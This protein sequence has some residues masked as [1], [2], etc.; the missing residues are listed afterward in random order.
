[1]EVFTKR[2]GI[3]VA[4]LVI[5]FLIS[6][7]IGQSQNTQSF[8]AA[9]RSFE[10]QDYQKALSEINSFL[11]EVDGNSYM[12]GQAY[13][14]Q[15]KILCRLDQ[16]EQSLESFQL[17]LNAVRSIDYLPRSKVRTEALLMIGVILYSRDSFEESAN[18]LENSLSAFHL[19]ESS[20]KKLE[21]TIFEYLAKSYSELEDIDKAI[22]YC[23]KAVEKATELQNTKLVAELSVIQ[24][25]NYRYID[26]FWRAIKLQRR[27]NQIFKNLAMM[28]EYVDGIFNIGLLFYD[29]NEPDS[30][31][32]YYN[33]SKELALKEDIDY[34]IFNVNY[35]LGYKRM[36]EQK[37]AEAVTFFQSAFSLADS[38][39][40]DE[41]KE[42]IRVFLTKIYYSQGKR[43][44]AKGE[45][46]KIMLPLSDDLSNTDKYLAYEIIS[47]IYEEEGDIKN[48]Y[49]NLKLAY[50]F[51]ENEI[52]Y[53]HKNHFKRSVAKN[54]VK[55]NNEGL[56]LF[57]LELSPQEQEALKLQRR[58]LYYF[59]AVI[60]ILFSLF[61]MYLFVQNKK[62]KKI[63]EER[64]KDREENEKT[65]KKYEAVK[66]FLESPLNQV[67][68]PFL[69]KDKSKINAGSIRYIHRDKGIVRLYLEGK[70]EPIS[71]ENGI[72]KDYQDRLY[73]PLIVRSHQS[74]LVNIL[75]VKQY[76][77]GRDFLIMEGA[78][79]DGKDD[80]KIPV[81]K[82]KKSE[83]FDLFKKYNSKLMVN[84]SN[85]SQNRPN[86]EE[87]LPNKHNN[88]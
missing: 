20:N 44:L 2:T 75:K 74:Y 13:L 40:F 67:E 73:F 19:S 3:D 45:L 34:I 66:E 7:T 53:P 87:N 48:A 56:F 35:N 77:K 8:K 57:D 18:Y 42:L 59:L 9:Q 10:N 81:A 69:L 62:R 29:M 47:S 5:I 21:A 46:E 17:A 12:G 63:E 27:A 22:M 38:L 31:E 64:A 1:M 39:E 33:E 26:E 37:Y 85:L 76:Q 58:S 50:E 65:F 84:D 60:L 30:S 55:A 14:L 61:G 86:I 23:D 41:D 15:G 4:F 79:K 52:S 49:S 80:I 71:D 16:E 82:S 36:Y 11:E 25:F 6:F 51:I 83:F 78:E 43:K 68:L 70:K 72:L 54:L 24:V 28:P 88:I 32:Y